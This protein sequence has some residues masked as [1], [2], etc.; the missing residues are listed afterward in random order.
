MGLLQKVPLSGY[1]LN[2]KFDDV[3]GHFWSAEQSQIY[4][5]LY[6]LRDLEWVQ[7][8]EIAQSKSPNKKIY[9]LTEIGYASLQEWLLQPVEPAPYRA[10]WL[11]QLFFASELKQNDMANLLNAKLKKWRGELSILGKRMQSTNLKE[12]VQIQI[13]GETRQGIA[14][15]AFRYNI[16]ISRAQIKWAEEMLEFLKDLE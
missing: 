12:A 11:G 16:D 10:L 2:K 4:R 1:D 14:M 13:T 9:H 15:M 7:I 5:A 3:L 8:E 6:K